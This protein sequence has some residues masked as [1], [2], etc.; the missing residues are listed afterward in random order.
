M[1]LP[2]RGPQRMETNDPKPGRPALDPDAHRI[3][4]PLVESAGVVSGASGFIGRAVLRRLPPGVR[5]Y[6]TY[7]DSTDFPAWAET[8][9]AEVAPVRIDLRSTPL[10]SVVPRVDWALLLAARVQTAA[11]RADPLGELT[12]VSGVAINSVRGLKAARLLHLSSGSVYETLAGELSP[13]RVLRPRLPYSIAKLAAEL[14]FESYADAPYW[15]IRFFGA[16]GPGEP[17]FKLVRRLVD[18]FTGGKRSFSLQGDGTNRIDPMYIDE[19]ALALCRALTLPP[20]SKTVDLCQGEGPTI[21]DFARLA[22]HAASTDAC[23]S[24][25]V[26]RFMGE[27]HEQMLGCAHPHPSLR[28]PR[29]HHMTLWEGL[30]RYAEVLGSATPV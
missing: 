25:P 2:A 24:E 20:E 15:N 29:A 9:A 22:F 4:E 23:N 5:V 12:S 21:R 19:A 8:C 10:C 27:A 6:A 11:S 7:H 14:L 30:R 28:V 26:L 18:D 3:L 16:Y 1:T 13:D 17:R